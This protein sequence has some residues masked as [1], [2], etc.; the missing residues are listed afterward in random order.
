M[1]SRASVKMLA[2]EVTVYMNSCVCISCSVWAKENRHR[3][4]NTHAHMHTHTHTHTCTRNKATN[5]K[6]S[7]NHKQCLNI[8][9]HVS[10]SLVWQQW[11]WPALP[12]ALTIALVTSSRA[13]STTTAGTLCSSTPTGTWWTPTGPHDTSSLRRTCQK[14][15]SVF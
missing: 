10:A 11:C 2:D 15:W 3:H 12:K 14:T 6:I 5:H 1:L 13:M 8:I 7:D 4:T 9:V